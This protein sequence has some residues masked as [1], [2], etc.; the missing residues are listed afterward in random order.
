MCLN[1][2]LQDTPISGILKM[3]HNII[4]NVE[5]RPDAKYLHYQEI[6][7]NVMRLEWYVWEQQQMG[8]FIH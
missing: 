7:L 6:I 5:W 3:F 4:A 8:E 2:C 1:I